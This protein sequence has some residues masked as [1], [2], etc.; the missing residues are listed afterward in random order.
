MNCNNEDKKEN[1]NI[2]TL[3][4]GVTYETYQKPWA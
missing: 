3:T 4:C 2:N 1:M